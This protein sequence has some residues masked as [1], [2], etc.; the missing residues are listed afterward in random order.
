MEQQAEYQNKL[1]ATQII[2]RDMNQQM[3]HNIDIQGMLYKYDLPVQNKE[4]EFDHLKALMNLEAQESTPNVN[5]WET[6]ELDKTSSFEQ[7]VIKV[8]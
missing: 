5:L 4:L 3:K 7:Y 6:L 1:E 8:N 2:S